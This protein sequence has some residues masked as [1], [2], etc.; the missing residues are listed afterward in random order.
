MRLKQIAT[1][2]ALRIMIARV[3][4]RNRPE[5]VIPVFWNFRNFSRSR[6]SAFCRAITTTS[7]N[8]DAEHGKIS[9]NIRKELYMVFTCTKCETRAVKGFSKR[10]YEHGVV[11]VT[12]PG[13]ERRHVVA[14][15]MGWFGE[16]GCASDFVDEGD[17]QRKIPNAMNA[18]VS[19]DGI[20]E[21]NEDELE[22]FRESLDVDNR[23]D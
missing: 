4:K 3:V 2:N 12:C 23:G 7:S 10:A 15:R 17:G 22:R 19:E 9:G 13:C 1:S 16:K 11:I 18:R 6:D 21:F 14:D 20:I 8:T 5:L